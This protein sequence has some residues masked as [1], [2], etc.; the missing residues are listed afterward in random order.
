MKNAHD[1]LME[2]QSLVETLPR[3]NAYCVIAMEALEDHN[4]EMLEI[5]TSYVDQGTRTQ[6]VIDSRH[7][8]IRRLEDLHTR[9][10]RSPK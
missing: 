6:L 8:L 10:L 1:F 5:A 3:D 9:A 7:K 4:Q 2:V